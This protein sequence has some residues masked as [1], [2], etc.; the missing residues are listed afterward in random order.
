[1]VFLMFMFSTYDAILCYFSMF[2]KIP[3]AI[4]NHRTVFHN[5]ETD[6]LIKNDTVLLCST[7]IQFI[8][9]IVFDISQHFTF[10]ESFSRLSGGIP[11]PLYRC[12]F[13]NCRAHIHRRMFMT[14]GRTLEYP[15]IPKHIF[16]SCTS[17]STRLWHHWLLCPLSSKILGIPRE[18]A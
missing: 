5:A 18:P 4:S 17:S 13:V 8:A 3:A 1:M 9:K 15:Q 16:T 6:G 11:A 10:S 14:M 2:F 7:F 12:I